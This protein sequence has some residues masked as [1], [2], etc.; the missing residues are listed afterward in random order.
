MPQWVPTFCSP[1]WECKPRNGVN[2][3]GRL[4]A[5]KLHAL[6]CVR[7]CRTNTRC[8][9][10]GVKGPRPGKRKSKKGG[11]QETSG[12][13]HKEAQGT[14]M[15]LLLLN[16]PQ[17]RLHATRWVKA[18]P[19]WKSSCGVLAT[20]LPSWSLA[21]Y[22]PCSRFHR[23]SAGFLGTSKQTRWMNAIAITDSLGESAINKPLIQFA[24]QGLTF[25]IKWYCRQ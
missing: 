15:L 6:L 25:C 2:T 8:S 9:V 10:K 1:R 18:E 19:V 13:G 21:G 4:R 16:F 3:A 7:C 20:P 23:T 5:C 22:L 17:S 14:T 11:E 24:L 12:R